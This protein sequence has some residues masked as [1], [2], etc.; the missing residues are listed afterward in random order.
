MPPNL[1]SD[2]VE[3]L[4]Y[5]IEKVASRVEEVLLGK[6]AGREE[7]AADDGSLLCLHK[8]APNGSHNAGIKHE[9]LRMLVRSW[10]CSCDLSLHLPGGASEFHIYSKRGWYRFCP[11]N[12]A[13]I[14]TVGDQIQLNPEVA[15]CIAVREPRNHD[16]G[17]LVQLFSRTGEDFQRRSSGKGMK[18]A[19]EIDENS[20]PFFVGKEAKNLMTTAM[21][22]AAKRKILSEMNNRATL[23]ESC[24][25][26]RLGAQMGSD[27]YSRFCLCG[28][29]DDACSSPSNPVSYDPLTNYTRPRPQFLRYNQHRRR[30]IL[31]RIVGEKREED[32]GSG[33]DSSLSS[34]PEKLDAE[35]LLP[36]PSKSLQEC[37]KKEVSDVEDIITGEEEEEEMNQRPGWSK[38]AW[39][40]V[41]IGILL[42]SSYY[43]SSVS[44]D[45]EQG[46]FSECFARD[47]D[48]EGNHR[49]CDQTTFSGNKM[50]TLMGLSK[51][52]LDVP[53][54]ELTCGNEDNDSN[55]SDSD[56]LI[57][58]YP[59]ESKSLHG[60]E[61]ATRK[62]G[63]SMVE[64][65]IGTEDDFVGEAMTDEA[66]DSQFAGQHKCSLSLPAE[67]NEEIL[68][69]THRVPADSSQV[70]ET[71]F[72][73][74]TSSDD[75]DEVVDFRG[76]ELNE[77]LW[78][79]HSQ[80][81]SSLASD[82]RKM[83]ESEVQCKWDHNF[84]FASK[85]VLK[86]L[87]SIS[88]LSTILYKT[89]L[90][91]QKTSAPASTP[92]SSSIRGKEDKKVSDSNVCHE[93]LSH[94]SNEGMELTGTR[95][96][97]VEL[98]GEFTIVG[99]TAHT[100]GSTQSFRVRGADP[101]EESQLQS[102]YL[103]ELTRMNTSSTNFSINQSETSPI[104]N[105]SPI[106]QRPTTIRE[107]EV[108]CILVF[109]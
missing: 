86:I 108:S 49:A 29:R 57:M 39:K 38:L 33:G 85:N 27:L 75:E 8:H 7:E 21:S 24:G 12:A 6:K 4:W 26:A 104:M 95:P 102:Q 84:V 48:G 90:K 23:P 83:D 88:L 35:D 103:R 30:Q 1:C 61:V 101:V 47:S 99:R 3:G 98:L 68:G 60:I 100:T 73:D 25:D 31:M 40:M 2:K 70:S 80:I 46:D 22:S 17:R 44:S 15:K 105:T 51:V 55:L 42:F 20:R 93:P 65:G 58:R 81:F 18:A 77:S 107:E 34:D 62:D 36:A 16:R 78:L 109:S 64:N 87:V 74:T 97:V 53:H 89:F 67:W 11:E 76:A 5:E 14:V 37:E 54:R 72:V 79:P 56:G 82:D 96:P 50:V 43:V 52:C 32:Y 45:S 41:L 13:I 63:G 19:G 71:Q 69:D 106:V 59:Q 94:T 66:A 28:D 91:H 9:L 10:S 92:T